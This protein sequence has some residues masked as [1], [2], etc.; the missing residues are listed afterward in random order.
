MKKILITGSSGFIGSALT[1]R[2]LK[3]QYYV[4]GLDNHN[5]FYDVKLKEDRLKRHIND[6]KYKNYLLDIKDILKLT[7]VFEEND[8]DIVIN[9]AA[10][11]GVEY[12]TKEPLEYVNSNITGFV[13][14]LEC[15]KNFKN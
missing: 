1:L 7:K 4:V 5:N 13:N 2:L 6:K 12:S 8:I 3:E 14:I 10:Q 11:A 15:C 9:L